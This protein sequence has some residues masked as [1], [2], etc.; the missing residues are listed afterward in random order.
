[1][2]GE[3]DSAG[4]HIKHLFHGIIAVNIRIWLDHV[5]LEL[6]EECEVYRECFYEEHCLWKVLCVDYLRPHNTD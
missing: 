2:H 6:V 5:A 3:Q 1:M 4:M